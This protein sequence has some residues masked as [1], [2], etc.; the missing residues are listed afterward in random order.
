MK[1]NRF[2]IEDVFDPQEG[3]EVLLK[4]SEI[5]CMYGPNLKKEAKQEKASVTLG[6]MYKIVGVH[7]VCEAND[8]QIKFKD[9]KGNIVWLWRHYFIK[10]SNS[11]KFIIS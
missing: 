6:K 11:M 5:N 8:C 10:V 7:P 4:Y 3:D 2:P 1:I 9:D